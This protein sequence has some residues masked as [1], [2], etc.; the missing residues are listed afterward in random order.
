MTLKRENLQNNNLIFLSSVLYQRIMKNQFSFM[1][2]ITLYKIKNWDSVMSLIDYKITALHYVRFEK[3]ELHQHTPRKTSNVPHFPFIQ[4]H[5][6]LTDTLSF[7]KVDLHR[8][9][10]RL[11][12]RHALLQ[13]RYCWQSPKFSLM[14]DCQVIKRNRDRLE[15]ETQNAHLQRFFYRLYTVPRRFPVP[16]HRNF[17][18]GRVVEVTIKRRSTGGSTSGAP[19]A[20]GGGAGGRS[21]SGQKESQ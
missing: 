3:F 9:L 20:G 5:H 12:V 7:S 14:N 8:K 2:D 21:I 16:H 13:P 17:L 18:P 11:P 4:L 19:N 1:F 10:Y 6:F 15:P